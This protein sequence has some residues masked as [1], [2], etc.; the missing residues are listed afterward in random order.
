MLTR[1]RRFAQT[2]EAE[3]KA[4]MAEQRPTFEDFERLIKE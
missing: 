1:P 2:I 3:L 4:L